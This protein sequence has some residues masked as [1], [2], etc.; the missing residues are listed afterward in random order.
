MFGKGVYLADVSS[1]SANYCCHHQSGGA[2]LLLLCEAELGRPMYELTGASYTAG[3]EAREKGCW[4][5]W[6]KG[7][8]APQWWKDAGNVHEALKGVKM[9]SWMLLALILRLLF[10]SCCWFAA[11]V[12][13]LHA[14]WLS[15]MVLRWTILAALED[16]RLM[17]N[18][19]ALVARL[20]V[21]KEVLLQ[22][23]VGITPALRL[24]FSVSSAW[25]S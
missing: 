1:K 5:T 12:T 10:L 3:E 4:A 6:G 8:T 22:H 16:A 24:L 15:L 13:T 23:T 18:E 2:A 19:I 7:M 21:F 14:T 20:L 17:Q 25:Q 9:V 11:L